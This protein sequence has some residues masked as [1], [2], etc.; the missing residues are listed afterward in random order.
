LSKALHTDQLNGDGEIYSPLQLQQ[1]R[2]Y[3]DILADI[4]IEI[5]IDKEKG[6]Q[7]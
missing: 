2:E 1:L 6:I 4:A 3:L 5:Y 7:R